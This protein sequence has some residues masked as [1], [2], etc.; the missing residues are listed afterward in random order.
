MWVKTPSGASHCLL[1][2]ETLNFFL[3]TVWFV[4]WI[5]ECFNKLI[6]FNTFKLKQNLYKLSLS[7]LYVIPVLQTNPLTCDV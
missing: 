2:Q 4:V 5:K 6:V 3:S 7:F 1:E